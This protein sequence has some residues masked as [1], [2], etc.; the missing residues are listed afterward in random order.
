MWM[1]CRA[2]GMPV[3][4]GQDGGG[5]TRCPF[6][7]LYHPDG[8]Q[9]PAFRVYSEHA[10]CFACW[11]YWTP[12][13]LAADAWDLPEE[14]AASRLLDETGT[15]PAGWEEEWDRV[16]A[17]PRPDASQLADAL[18]VFCSGE[19]GLDWE[20]ARMDPEVSLYLSQCLGYLGGVQTSQD[21]GQWLDLAKQVMNTVISGRRLTH[22]AR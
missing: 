20:Q 2:I 10:F 6:G 21:A 14:I 7:E 5:K 4:T 9:D 16:A 12:S 3:R 1:A 19:A 8:G 15:R 13:R 22:G 17:E 11:K 18:R